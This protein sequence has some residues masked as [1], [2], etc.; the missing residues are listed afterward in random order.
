MSLDLTA[1]EWRIIAEALLFREDQLTTYRAL[2][3][4]ATRDQTL[5]A[6]VRL[7]SVQRKLGPNARTAVRA[8]VRPVQQQSVMGRV[9]PFRSRLP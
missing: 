7:R 9:I 5:A 4:R 6:L 3:A 8:G 1:D 2:R